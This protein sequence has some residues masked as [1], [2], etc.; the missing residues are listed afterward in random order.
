VRPKLAAIGVAMAVTLGYA[1]AVVWLTWPLTSLATMHYAKTMMTALLDVPLVMWAL[2]HESRALFH[3]ASF[4]QAGIYHPTP[5]ALFYGEA[6]LGSLPLYAPVFLATGNPVLAIN[7]VFL[8][9][10]AMT[11]TMLHA[12]TQ[13]WSGSHLGGVVAG[14]TFLATPWVLWG[15]VTTA[16][17]Y[18]VLFYIPAIMVLAARLAPGWRPTLRLGGIVAVQGLTSVYV[19]SAV[20][21]PLGV[22]AVARCARPSTRRV[23][24]WMLAALVIAGG[25]LAVAF[26]GH[27]IVRARNSDIAAQSPYAAMSALAMDVVPSSFRQPI[28]PTSVPIASLALI[29]VGAAVHLS[30]SRHDRDPGT[31]TAW[32][33]CL[34]WIGVGL[35]VSLAP[36]VEVLGHV[37]STKWILPS[38]IHSVLRASDRLAMATLMGACVLA[39]VSFAE[40]ARRLPRRVARLGAP[41]LLAVVLAAISVGYAAPVTLLGYNRLPLDP[42]PTVTGRPPET[43]VEA[44]LHRTTG[45]LLEIPVG[46]TGLV[47][48][49]AMLLSIYHRHPLLNGYNGY[50]PAEYPARIALACRLPDR[51]ALAELARTTGVELIRVH[52]MALDGARHGGVGVTTRCPPDP[53]R[54]AAPPRTEAREWMDAA[55]DPS[56]TDLQLLATDGDQL[57]FRVKV[58]TPARP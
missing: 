44:A 3:P 28:R 55:R 56:R 26:S 54:D 27:A 17:N 5:Y 12:A 29:L 52:V 10:I 13:Q 43:R 42:Y 47:A 8:G 14:T 9:G 40:I 15:W 18:A 50:W 51:D 45:P 46:P 49:N 37:F 11:A 36:R 58:A 34:L 1:G 31:S 19:A 6:A 16:P 35:W 48:A 25:V 7:F 23:G 38:A 30:T 57:L 2:A 33:H 20:A 22:L 24:A 21:A 39:G 4:G 53:R 32:R 41:A